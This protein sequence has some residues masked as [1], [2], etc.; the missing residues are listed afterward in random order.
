MASLHCAQSPLPFTPSCAA[1]TL[2]LTFLST[3]TPFREPSSTASPWGGTRTPSPPWRGPS[4][5]PITGRSRCPRAGSRAVR[6]SRRPRGWPRASMN[7]IASDS[8]LQGSSRA[9][10]KAKGWSALL[11]WSDPAVDPH[12]RPHLG[13]EPAAVSWEL[14]A[15]ASLEKREH[16]LQSW[17]SRVVA[18]LGQWV[19]LPKCT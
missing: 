4:P 8:E 19:Q 11:L 13:R 2:I 17:I 15:R 14:E 9:F 5:A 7:S 18:A 1:W 16:P 12:H 6:L 3:T 10:L